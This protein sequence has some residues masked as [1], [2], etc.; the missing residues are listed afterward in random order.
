MFSVSFQIIKN[1]KEKNKYG[2]W[3]EAFALEGC[4]PLVLS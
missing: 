1:E 4:I 3:P 2:D